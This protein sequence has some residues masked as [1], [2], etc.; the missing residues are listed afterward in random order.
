MTIGKKISLALA[1]QLGLTVIFG[2]VSVANAERI[3][4][5]VHSIAADA[6]PGV[7]SI[8]RLTTYA[9]DQKVQMLMHLFAES[10]EQ[11]SEAES[12]IS[13]LENKF[14]NELKTYEKTVSSSRGR[15]VFERLAPAQDQVMRVWAKIQPLD[16]AAKPKEAM[17]I[18]RSEG[19]PITLARQRVFDAGLEYITTNGNEQGAEAASAGDSARFWAI[20]I[21]VCSALTGVALATLIV[22]GI[23]Q[24]LLQVAGEL[25]ENAEQVSSASGQVSSRASRW[26]KAPPSR[27]PRSKRPPLR[28]KRWRP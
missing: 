4:G 8:T 17:A 18:W 16:R 26:R 11:M 10:P 25:G 28:A 19:A 22:R 21:L 1:A 5:I 9:K 15:E 23:N 3:N 7:E 6:L 13:D 24:T 12:N 2:V 27:R 20:I 14:Q